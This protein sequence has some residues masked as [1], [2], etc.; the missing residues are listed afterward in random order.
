MTGISKPNHVNS[1]LNEVL[2]SNDGWEASGS[3][4]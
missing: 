1:K 2:V 3:Q 4:G